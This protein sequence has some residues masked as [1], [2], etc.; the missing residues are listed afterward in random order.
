MAETATHLASPTSV[1]ATFSTTS[2]VPPI[3][4]GTVAITG[5]AVF[6]QTLT[7]VPNLTS[8][9]PEEL[10]AL[11]YQWKRGDANIGMNSTTYT[12]VQSDIGSTITVTVTAENCTGSVTSNP[13]T[14]ITKA[15]QTTPT[16]P[17]MAS[18][19]PTSITLNTVSGCEYN[20]S[21]GTFQSSPMF[22]ELTPN[23]SYIFTQRMAE[24]ATHL[25][26]PT[27]EAA[28]FSTGEV[29]IVETALADIR[30]YPNPTNDKFIVELDG[31][32]SI[33]LYDLLGKEVLFQ[34]INGKTEI[35]ISYLPNGVYNVNFLSEGRVI[36]NSKIV[37]Q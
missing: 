37:K 14:T 4:G 35:D 5:N 30:I 9:P 21:G 15:T 32:A 27:S 16:A 23:T 13:T 31:Y 26:S 1:A 20:I 34:T 29:S 22:T 25:A 6:E 11:T 3:L 28:T 2:G 10:G 18:S 36:G 17:T 24:T 33:K 8:T 19:T 7:A 12:L